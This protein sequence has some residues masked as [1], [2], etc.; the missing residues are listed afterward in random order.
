M[1]GY[2]LTETSPVVAANIPWDYEFDDGTKVCGHRDGTVGLPF[3]GTKIKITD[4]V[5]GEN[6]ERC[7]E[8]MIAVQGP[9]VMKGYLR[10]P[11]RTR[12]VL[13]DGWFVTGDVGFVD[14]DGF[15][16]VTGRLSQFAKIAGEMVP[17]LGV[18]EEILEVAQ[19]PSHCLAITS[20]PDAKRG[21]RLAV[22]YTEM[23]K[24]PQEIVAKLKESSISRLWI[25]DAD[26]FV[27]VD[28]LPVLPTGKLDLLAIR[29]IAEQRLCDNPCDLCT[30]G[31]AQNAESAPQTVV[32]S[33]HASA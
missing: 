16:T 33:Q 1:Q 10:D 21:E 24:T 19:L 28:D 31:T 29:R 18:E 5:T 15:L 27:K 12:D 23:D 22:V 8:G 26:D 32:I 30:S 20:V 17:H 4:L 6:L 11:I 14:H 9:Q 13:D 2:G 25:P 7:R 3:P